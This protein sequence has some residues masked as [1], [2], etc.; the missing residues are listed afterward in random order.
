MTDLERIDGL[1]V[2]QLNERE[3]RIFERAV[4]DGEAVRTWDHFI[5]AMLG[6]AKV[7]VMHDDWQ[8]RCEY[9]TG[10]ALD[11]VERDFN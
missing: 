2:G 4:K 9:E 6:I 7:K 3:L 10:R 11:I 5:C 8:L 1:Y